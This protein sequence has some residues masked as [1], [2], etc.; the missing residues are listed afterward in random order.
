MNNLLFVHSHTF[1][2]AI[3]GAVLSVFE[4]TLTCTYV[5]EATHENETTNNKQQHSTR[6]KSHHK[7]H[8]HLCTGVINNRWFCVVA[9]IFLL[10]Q[11]YVWFFLSFHFFSPF[12]LFYFQYSWFAFWCRKIH[13]GFVSFKA[14]WFHALH[15]H[16]C[17]ICMHVP[18]LFQFGFEYTQN[19]NSLEFIWV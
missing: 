10:L 15:K 1:L 18:F 7:E 16:L 2:F 11:V 5:D 8:T 6:I 13:G 19:G 4:H 14:I 17:A 9:F 3:S 12:A